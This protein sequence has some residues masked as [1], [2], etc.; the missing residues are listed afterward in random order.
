MR[1]TCGDIYI[2]G[3]LPGEV[4]DLLEVLQAAKNVRLE[5][6][7]GPHEVEVVAVLVDL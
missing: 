4:V 6:R 7:P 5:V 2:A 1:A 3:T